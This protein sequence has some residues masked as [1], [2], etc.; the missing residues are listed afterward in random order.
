MARLFLVRHGE[1]VWNDAQRFQGH[2]DV[3]LSAR[4]WR[5]AE[6]LAERFACESIAAIYASDLSRARDTAQV[7]AGRLCKVVQCEPLLREANLGE[8]QGLGYAQV[9]DRWF[10]ASDP[11][12]CYF[13]DTAPPGIECLRQLQA[14]VMGALCNLAARHGGETILVV[15]HGACLRAV[16]CAWL[17]IALS[18]HARLN[19]D[20]GSVSEIELHPRGASVSLLNDVSH[21]K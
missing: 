13:V 17:G 21:L 5:Q 12:P 3:P 16:L 2:T 7:I 8:L 6:W 9:R 10:H 11:L 15:M 1:T 14:R 19:F 20:P 18:E 4:G